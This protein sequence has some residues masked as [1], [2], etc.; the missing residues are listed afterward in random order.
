MRSIASHQIPEVID[1]RL[2][3]L[4]SE[5]N[6]DMELIGKQYSKITYILLHS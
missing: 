3:K 2:F 4:T 6:A 5:F 1:K